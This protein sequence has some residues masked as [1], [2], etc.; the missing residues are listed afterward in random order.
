MLGAPAWHF[1][2]RSL[3]AGRGP[4][5]PHRHAGLGRVGGAHE[6]SWGHGPHWGGWG[7]GRHHGPV[8]S[9]REAMLTRFE[10][11][12][13][14]LEEETIA[15]AARIKELRAAAAPGTPGTAPGAPPAHRP[16][17]ETGPNAGG[18][19]DAAGGAG[20][21]SDGSHSFAA[22]ARDRKYVFHTDTEEE[23]LSH[24]DP[25][26]HARTN[27]AGDPARDRSKVS[28]RRDAET[29]SNSQGDTCRR[30]V[31]FRRPATDLRLASG[32]RTWKP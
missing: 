14:D 2:R 29:H 15:V 30:R 19:A 24:L 7:H 31:N 28:L 26:P 12:Q 9:S 27:L 5:G 10:Q 22:R 3:H 16:G 6:S 23:E 32:E 1:W 18:G 11:H 13:R 25:D 20:H 8:G 21:S 17:G 4:A